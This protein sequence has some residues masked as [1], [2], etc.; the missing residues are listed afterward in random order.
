MSINF[1]TLSCNFLFLLQSLIVFAKPIKFALLFTFG[2]VLAVGR[3]VDG[4]LSLTEP[5]TLC[6]QTK[7]FGLIESQM[8]LLD[9]ITKNSVSTFTHPCPRVLHN[10]CNFVSLTLYIMLSSLI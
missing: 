10:W 2:N 7:Y 9:I 6:Y 3:L 1:L 4:S 8:L 5:L